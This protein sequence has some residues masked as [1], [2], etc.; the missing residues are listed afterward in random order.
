MALFGS[1][2]FASSRFASSSSDD[3]LATGLTVQ[4]N[5]RA[6]NYRNKTLKI[7]DQI[8]GRSTAKFKFIDESPF[9]FADLA[10]GQSVEIRKPT[11]NALVFR[12]TIDQWDGEELQIG[13]AHV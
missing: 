7:D 12:G 8:D 3:E 10:V 11:T 13:R 5:G 6:C 4:L 9:S 2:Q 1:R